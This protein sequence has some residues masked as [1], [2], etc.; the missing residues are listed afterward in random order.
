[1]LSCA[2]ALKQQNSQ[3]ELIYIGENDEL[4][5]QLVRS[6]GLPPRYILAGKWRRY[7]ADRW[8]AQV[9]DW[10]THILN[11]RDVFK[12]FIGFWQSLFI[13]LRLQPQVVFVKGG[14]VGLPVGIAAWLLGKPLIIHESD[15]VP[16]LTNRVLAHLSATVATGWPAKYYPGWDG[17]HLKFVGNPIRSEFSHP[18]SVKS[19]SKLA[20][21]RPTLLVIGGSRGARAI[22]QAVSEHLAELTA[23]LQVIHISGRGE[24]ERLKQVASEQG[25]S[26]D[27]H[28]Y[29]WLELDELIAAYRAATVIVSRAGM[30]T[31]AEVAAIGRPLIVVPHPNTPGDHQ[32]RN[33]LALE[34]EQAAIMIEQ[35]QLDNRL[36]PAVKELL[37]A[38]EHQQ[39][40][41]KGIRHLAKP[42]AAQALAKAILEL[43]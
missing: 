42:D 6:S 29:P 8:W 34:Q 2:Q 9:I 31:L 16:G 35:A 12:L 32:R 43:A 14:Y 40:L 23:D 10:Q 17:R 33:A 5:N 26:R 13:L 4:T 22:N 36:V 20:R 37:A 39:L 28:L 3:V 25:I 27:Y 38:S 24:Y 21:Q 19:G 30:N 41:I 7:P 18:A 1:M 15:I 11:F